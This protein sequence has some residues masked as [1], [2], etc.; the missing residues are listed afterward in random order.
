VPLGAIYFL[1]MMIAVPLEIAMICRERYRLASAASVPI[2]RVSV[3]TIL[4]TPLLIESVLRVH[5]D[6][7]FILFLN[8]LQ[9]GLVG[10]LMWPLLAR[11]GLVGG[12]WSWWS[13]SRS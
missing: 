10:L 5:A 13:R 7:R 4:F 3:L 11:F 6:T 8:C 12:V 2:F 1:F 9:L